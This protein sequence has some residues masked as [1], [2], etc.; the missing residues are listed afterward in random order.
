V[1]I[2]TRFFG[3]GMY[4]GGWSRWWHFLRTVRAA[5]LR[6]IPFVIS[7]WITGLS[8]KAYAEKYVIESAEPDP[9]SVE[10]YTEH[11]RNKLRA[12][13]DSGALEITLDSVR[14]NLC[15]TL[16]SA[17]DSSGLARATSQISKLLRK[18]KANVTLRIEACDAESVERLLRRL[19]RYGDRI[20]LSVSGALREMVTVDSSRFHLVFETREASRS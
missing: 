10:R 4:P 14:T 7:E 3:A 19:R 11:L 16:N 5:R 12:W 13:I 17:V 1:R 20:S 15:V 9:V 8:M 6:Q 2:L 18:T